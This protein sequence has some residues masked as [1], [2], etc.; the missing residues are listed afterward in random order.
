MSVGDNGFNTTYQM[1]TF[2]QKFGR[3]EKANSD[4]LKQMGLQRSA[5]ARELRVAQWKSANSEL[6]RKNRTHIK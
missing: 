4:R 1:R 3:F 6:R 5:F 2:S